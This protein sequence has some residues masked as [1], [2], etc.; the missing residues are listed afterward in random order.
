VICDEAANHRRIRQSPNEGSDVSGW[1]R[2][3]EE[4][5]HWRSLDAPATFWW[6][7]DDAVEPT[8]RLDLLLRHA[9]SVPLSMAVIPAL[10]TRALA[11]CLRDHPLVAVLQHGWRHANHATGGN[12]EYPACRPVEEV[13]RE[14]A[15]GL[16]LLVN[17]F[18]RQAVPVFAPPWHGFDECFLPMLRQNGFVAISRKGPRAARFA[19]EGVLQANAHLAPIKWSDPPSFEDDDLYLD[20]IIEHLR[21]RRL[22][23][24]DATE[25]TGLLT[26]HLVQNDKSYEFIARFV[27]IVS[28]HPA[29]VWRDAKSIF[30]LDAAPN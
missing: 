21:G 30:A 23:R 1:S 8:P 9:E 19:A 28:E 4:L 29:A 22:G 5:D 16:A 17:L 7:D 25:A 15:E 20:Q 13:S 10:A 11:E 2:L 27:A 18:G 14:F 26:H 24:Y 6:R 3:T 12:S